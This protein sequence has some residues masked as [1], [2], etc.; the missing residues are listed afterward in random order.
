MHVCLIVPGPLTTVS[1]GHTY[2]RRMADGLRALG[3]DVRVIE[4]GGRL[5]DP[6]QAAIYA[7]RTAWGALPRSAAACRDK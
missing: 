6:D 4:L 5:P 1:G 7:A 2:D 3:H